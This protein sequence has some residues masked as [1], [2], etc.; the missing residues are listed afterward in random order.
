MEEAILNK[1]TRI[2]SL[3]KGEITKPLT[4]DEASKY[5]DISKSYI[6]KL[7]C[8]NQIPHYKPRGKRL[9][10]LKSELTD[11]VLR[12]PGQG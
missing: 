12:N 2:E 11:W 1:L 7:T 10:F 4:L 5:L 3:L 8:K 6:Y 9:Y